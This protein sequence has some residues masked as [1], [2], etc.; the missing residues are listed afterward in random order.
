MSFMNV[1][2]RECKGVRLSDY[3]MADVMLNASYV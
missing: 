3:A 1:L 2:V